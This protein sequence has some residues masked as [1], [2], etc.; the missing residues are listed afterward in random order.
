MRQEANSRKTKRLEVKDRKEREKE[1]K[2]E[3]IKQLKA[4]KRKEIMEKLDKLKKIAG[5]EDLGVNEE[6]L[7]EDFDPEKYDKRMKELFEV[8]ISHHNHLRMQLLWKT[9]FSPTTQLFRAKKTW[10]NQ[11]FLI[12]IPTWKQN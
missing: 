11:S 2:R 4:F 8:K 7:E 6:D 5:A 9:V 1:K 10:K 12:W 3:E